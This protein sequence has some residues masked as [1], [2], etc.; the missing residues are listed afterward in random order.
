MNG[1][2]TGGKAIHYFHFNATIT[3]QRIH[4]SI[5]VCEDVS[6]LAS[7]IYALAYEQYTRAEWNQFDTKFIVDVFTNFLIEPP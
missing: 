1:I 4:G 7:Y 2:M 6:I 5:R 3:W